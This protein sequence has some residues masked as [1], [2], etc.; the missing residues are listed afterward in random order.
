VVRKAEWSDNVIPASSSQMAINLYTLS[1][2]FDD[3]N[4]R[5]IS[6]KLLKSVIKE[7]ES[8]GPGYSNWALLLLRN[9]KPQTEVVIVGKSVN[10]KLLCLYKQS[11]PN[12][13]FALSDKTS[14][15][16]L[17]KNRYVEGQTL[18]YVCKNNSCL[19]PTE[20]V[21]EALKQIEEGTT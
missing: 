11:P 18:I 6:Q 21:A 4:Y 5:Q 14:D 1:V 2:Y 9:L 15:L 8:Y 12:V 10:E 20:T 17:L 13:I 3:T 19:L 16:P 7:I